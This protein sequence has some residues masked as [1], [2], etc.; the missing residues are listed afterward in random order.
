[1]VKRK[2]REATGSRLVAGRWVPSSLSVVSASPQHPLCGGDGLRVSDTVLG[3][4][5]PKR[6]LGGHDWGR[7]SI[8][9]APIPFGGR[10]GGAAG[11][12]LSSQREDWRRRDGEMAIRLI[13]GMYLCSDYLYKVFF[14]GCTRVKH[15]NNTFSIYYLA[16]LFRATLTDAQNRL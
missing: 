7:P 6:P 12:A 8:W 16:I 1:M 15:N 9:R 3:R 5:G 11:D 13:L 4:A 14:C 10:L 2:A